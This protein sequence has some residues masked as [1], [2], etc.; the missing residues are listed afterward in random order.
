VQKI[1]FVVNPK[2]G[3]R[4][5]IDLVNF[6]KNHISEQVQYEIL[7]WEPIEKFESLKAYYLNNAFDVVVACGGDGT[8]NAVA[9]SLMH[10][11]IALGI[12][13]LGSGNGLARS[14]GYP[15]D[16]KAALDF[17]CKEKINKI[18]ANQIQQYT[19]FCIGGVG[20][21]AHVS[22]LFAN[23]KARGLRSYMILA[24]K[25]YF[26]HPNHRYQITIDSKSYLEEAFLISCANANQYGNNAY[27]APDA[28]MQ[29]EQAE[30]I[31]LKKF[32]LWYA[33]IAAWRLFRKSIYQSKYIKKLS[34]QNIRIES[35]EKVIAIHADGEPYLSESPIEIKVIPNCLNVVAKI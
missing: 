23:S 20:F 14:L 18:D 17:V 10:T 25:A 13:P 19:S 28:D 31:L 24:S 7:V 5:K 2:A 8:V 26:N 35:I 22:H 34:G 11:K 21:D 30:L 29:D 6:I 3:K 9:T 33:P 32:P 1:A 4:K 27:I 12:L 15:M 16:L